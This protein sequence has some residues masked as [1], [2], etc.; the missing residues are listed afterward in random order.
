M[1]QR[2]AGS[3]SGSSSTINT[4]GPRRRAQADRHRQR[5]EPSSGRTRLLA[6]SLQV[7]EWLAHALKVGLHSRVGV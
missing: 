2:A 1:P 6:A 3:A 4:K 5:E 7:D